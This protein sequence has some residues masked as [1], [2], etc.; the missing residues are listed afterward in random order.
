M[1]VIRGKG[2]IV[3]GRNIVVRGNGNTVIGGQ[4]GPAGCASGVIIGSGKVK[5]ERRMLERIG[6]IVLSGPA[7]LLFTRSATPFV[8]VTADDNI[9]PFIVTRASGNS[10]TIESSGNFSTRNEILVEVEM[11]SL[12]ALTAQG[13][14]NVELND[15][16]QPSLQVNLVGSGNIKIAGKVDYFTVELNGSGDIK[17]NSLK[18]RSAVLLLNGSGDI[19]AHASD[20]VK[21]RLNG[22]GDIEVS[23]RHTRRD[24]MIGGSGNIGF[25]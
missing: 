3:A 20:S 24:C 6:R 15:I 12:E 9:L 22:S 1:S 16:E 11:P 2:N 13:S 23:G 7:S 8:R 18:S 14:G 10:L 5:S 21:V 25:E 17:A 19:R 4:Y